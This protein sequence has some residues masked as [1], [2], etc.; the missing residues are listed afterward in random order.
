MSKKS[1]R[2]GVKKY[3]GLWVGPL[4]MAGLKYAQVRAHLYIC[5]IQLAKA[6]KSVNN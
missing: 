2:V 3:L 6:N 1:F 5:K 4:F